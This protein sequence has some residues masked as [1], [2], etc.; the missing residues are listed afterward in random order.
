MLHIKRISLCGPQPIALA[1]KGA[2]NEHDTENTCCITAK[3]V[4][5]STMFKET[6]FA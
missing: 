1:I 6:T 3:D 4:R 5:G 2:L